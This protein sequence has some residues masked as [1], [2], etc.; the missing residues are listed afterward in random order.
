MIKT[1]PEVG[2]KIR[3]VDTG[4]Y[5]F[6]TKGK[7]YE[8]CA[9]KFQDYSYALHYEDDNGDVKMHFYENGNIEFELVEEPEEVKK[10]K[11]MNIFKS[12]RSFSAISILALSS[13]TMQPAFAQGAEEICHEQAKVMSNIH[14]DMKENPRR[15][16]ITLETI[17]KERAT[18][19]SEKDEGVRELWYYIINR[20]SLSTDDFKKL[21][22]IRCYSSLR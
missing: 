8:V 20:L 13:C 2:T 4:G 9:S 6:L 17:E 14:R 16:E 18:K 19:T 12:I 5:R 22:F 1:K 7:V 3:C 11:Q 21:A 15:V 10:D